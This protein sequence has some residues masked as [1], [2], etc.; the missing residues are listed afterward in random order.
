VERG[1]TPEQRVTRAGLDLAAKRA[2]E[3]GVRAPAV[4]VLGA[5]AAAGLL[6]PDRGDAPHTSASTV[7]ADPGTVTMAL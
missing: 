4:I 1:S 3:L 2:D 7:A 6:E 5:V